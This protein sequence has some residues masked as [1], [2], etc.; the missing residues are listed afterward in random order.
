MPF[1]T[2][3]QFNDTTH[4]LTTHMYIV[5]NKLKFIFNNLMLDFNIR[6]Y[7]GISLIRLN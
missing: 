7:E 4:G 3:L 5:M 1:H 2:L 6:S